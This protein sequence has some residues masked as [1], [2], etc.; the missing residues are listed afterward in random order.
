MLIFYLN[1]NEKICEIKEGNRKIYLYKIIFLRRHY[2]RTAI[3]GII[4]QNNLLG[5]SLVEK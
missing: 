1:T 3:Y 5:W 2:R 4:Q